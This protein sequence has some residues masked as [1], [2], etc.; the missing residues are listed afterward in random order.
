M[1][2][3]EKLFLQPF[4]SEGEFGPT[5]LLYGVICHAGGGPN[6]GHYYAFVKSKEGRWFEMNDETV[7]ATSPPTDKKNAYMLFYMRN[8]GQALEAAVKTPATNGLVS[9]SAKSGLAAGMKKKMVKSK[10][11]GDNE[12]QGVKVTTPLLGPL[13]PSAE[14]LKGNKNANQS[15]SSIPIDPQA[16][17]LKSKIKAISSN[18][19]K[20]RKEFESLG[21]YESDSGEEGKKKTSANGVQD[22]QQ[23]DKMDE[24]VKGKQKR[25]SIS[26]DADEPPRPS[27]PLTQPRTSS[28]SPI[29]AASF[30]ASVNKN[31][32]RRLSE[33]GNQNLNR[34]SVSA[35]GA[36]TTGY[37][38]TNPFGKPFVKRKRM[39]I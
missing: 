5:Y 16:S 3:D 4:M 25:K 36:R 39:G 12:D 11:T 7:Q 8:K 33:T 9:A 22:S 1:Q 31:K 13:L 18:N 20:A 19:D 38:T 28:P 10:D 27:S 35:I 23:D 30:Y 15:S 21:D 14:I 17:A 29:P 2:Y 26:D 32:K 24:D 34:R 37:V 6:S